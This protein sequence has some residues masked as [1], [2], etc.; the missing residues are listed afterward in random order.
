[1]SYMSSKLFVDFFKKLYLNFEKICKYY[2]NYK[3]GELFLT[4]PFLLDV[5]S[6]CVMDWLIKRI[7]D[8]T[9]KK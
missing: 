3:K 8:I 6:V 2:T 1:M 5:C 9:Y 7:R 4:C